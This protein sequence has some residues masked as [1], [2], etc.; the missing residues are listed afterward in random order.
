MNIVLFIIFLLFA[1]FPGLSS[2][3]KIPEG[4]TQVKIQS[5]DTLGKLAPAE[6]W[7]LIRKVNRIDERHLPL[8]KKIL[9]V[10][11]LEKASQFL[12][13]PKFIAEAEKDAR[14]IYVFLNEQYFG[15][16]E[17]GKL[18]FWGPI[19]SGKKGRHT[20]SGKFKALWKAKS[21]HS[22]KYDADMPFAV[23]ISPDGY[24]FH[25]QALPGQP[26]SH[27]CIRLLREDAR[28]I[29]TWIEKDDPV[30]IVEPAPNFGA[31]FEK[32]EA[33]NQP[34]RAKKPIVYSW[35]N[36]KRDIGQC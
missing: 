23:N 2:A 35:R 8:G 5:G 24:F 9:I 34:K 11:D 7:D 32:C 6:H 30:I 26:A 13:V 22:K 1:A 33:K 20:P 19:S 12:P 3:E 18:S 28:A 29:F 10:A 14:T 17:Y 31:F 36:L 15:A 16:Y 27:G 21:Y 25:E 4:F